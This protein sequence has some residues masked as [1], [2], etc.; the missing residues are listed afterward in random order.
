MADNEEKTQFKLML[1][2]EVK[3]RLEEAAHEN[4]RSL[5]AEIIARLEHSVANPPEAV[6]ALKRQ[7]DALDDEIN[8]MEE[9]L[10]HLADNIK[11]LQGANANLK[12]LVDDSAELPLRLMHHILTYIDAVPDELAI[13]AYDM[14]QLLER[15]DFVSEELSGPE[16]THTETRRRLKMKRDEFRKQAIAQIKKKL[17]DPGKS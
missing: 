11:S 3:S 4:R 16:P 13:W 10:R 7:S 8:I 17:S 14:T 2:I 5:S 9:D 15:R 6:E 1:P 12:E